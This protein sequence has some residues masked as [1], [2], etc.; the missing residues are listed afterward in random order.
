MNKVVILGS[1]IV[2]VI[3]IAAGAYYLSSP[4]KAAASTQ[5]TT[6]SSTIPKTTIKYTSTIIPNQ[7]APYIT[8]AQGE[9][10]FGGVNI[11]N[12]KYYANLCSYSPIVNTSPSYTGTCTFPTGNNSQ[13][14]FNLNSNATVWQMSESFNQSLKGTVLDEVVFTNITN[15]SQSYSK[16][17][18]LAIQDNYSS[19][20]YSINA[21]ENGARYSV[22]YGP[23]GEF[24]Y[25]IYVLKGN[26][27]AAVLFG[28]E[29]NP[30][31]YGFNKTYVAAAVD[32]VT[33][34]LP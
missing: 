30:Q 2:L 20:N 22:F 32:T 23:R 8:Q 25:A 1:I 13:S 17:V 24:I 33:S 5:S 14:S 12:I 26:Y 6:Y 10:I 18:S 31:I 4:H 9:A 11:T 19:N 27:F 16:V 28:Q 15:S 29:P 3:I 34:E 7:S 21:T